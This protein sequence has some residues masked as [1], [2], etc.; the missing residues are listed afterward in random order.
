MLGLGKRH[1]SETEAMSNRSCRSTAQPASYKDFNTTGSRAVE[2][3]RQN[4]RPNHSMADTFEDDNTRSSGE[5][6]INDTELASMEMPTEEQYQQLTGEDITSRHKKGAATNPVTE[7]KNRRSRDGSTSSDSEV[8]IKAVHGADRETKMARHAN[9]GRNM[10]K[11]TKTTRS[12]NVSTG[13]DELDLH[14][15]PEEDDLDLNRNERGRKCSHHD[16]NSISNS[17]PGGRSRSRSLS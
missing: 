1:T 8:Q 2:A 13:E 3:N 9:K 15:N 6:S 12:K 5:T 4:D 10:N 14:M 16:H 17:M 7:R 11:T